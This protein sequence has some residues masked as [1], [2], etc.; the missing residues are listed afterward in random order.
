[1][2]VAR[3]ARHLFV[4][5]LLVV[6]LVSVSA[7]PAQAATG[8]VGGTVV[9]SQGAALGNVS[10]SPFRW[11]EQSGEW[12]V[13]SD[14]SFTADDGSYVISG[15]EPG[16]YILYYEDSINER[17]SVWSNGTSEM[18]ADAD[19]P[20]AFAV[21]DGSEAQ[22]DPVTME[23]GPNAQLEG[24][25]EKPDGSILDGVLVEAFKAGS[26]S[27]A[28]PVASD[29][30]YGGKYHLYVPAGDYRVEYSHLSGDWGNA[31]RTAT[32]VKDDTVVVA[33]VVM[34]PN[35]D[36]KSVSGTVA[37]LPSGTPAQGLSVYLSRVVGTPGSGYFDVF[38]SDMVTTGPG[39]TYHFDKL[40]AGRRYAVSVSQRG[41]EGAW[42]GDTAEA[43]PDS[44]FTAGATASLSTIHVTRL[45]TLTG[46]LTD[47]A[48]PA[49]GVDVQLLRWNAG[50]QTYDFEDS[51]VTDDTG[52]YALYPDHPGTF[53]L[54]ADAD[55][56][57]GPG[58]SSVIGATTLP[59]TAD[60]P[61]TFTLQA[62]ELRTVDDQALANATRIAGTVRD[63]AHPGGIGDVQVTAFRDDGAELDPAGYGETAADGTYR[64]KVYAGP[65]D[66][67]LYFDPPT[68]STG[69]GQWL[70]GLDAQPTPGALVPAGKVT[71]TSEGQS[72][73]GKDI[74]LADAPVLSGVVTSGGQ[75]LAGARV[76]AYQWDAE[77]GEWYSSQTIVTATDG[78]YKI[79]VPG[80]G[81]T[82]TV[83]VAKFGYYRTFLGGG[84]VLPTSPTSSN[85]VVASGP[86]TP[87]PSIAMTAVPQT[88]G[89]LAGTVTGPGGPAEHVY[90]QAC[91]VRGGS[92][93]GGD[94]T[95]H[96]GSWSI[97]NLVTGDYL[98]NYWPADTSLFAGKDTAVVEKDQT[99]TLDTTLGAP[100]TLPSGASITQGGRLAG[101]PGTVPTVYYAE[102]LTL[103][104]PG[105]AGVDNPTYTVHLDDGGADLHGPL[106]FDGATGTYKATVPPFEPR[107]GEATIT[108][109]IPA[110]GGGKVGFDLYIDPSGTVIDQFGQPVSG[111]D[112]E[113]Q[114][115][116]SQG[117]AYT[118]VPDG[119][120]IMSPSNRSNSMQTDANGAFHWDVTAGWYKVVASR[121]GC[122]TGSTPGMQVPP[123]RVDL[124][125]QLQCAAP[126]PTSLPTVT[127]ARSI[128][129]LL[130][131]TAGS[132]AGTWGAPSFQWRRNGV[133]IPGATGT[134][135]RLVPADA[136]QSI[137]VAQ[138][139][140]KD[141]F[142]PV[143]ATSAAVGVARA[144]STGAIRMYAAKIK[145]TQ[146]GIAL[147]TIKAASGL[148][149]TGR[150]TA[151]VDG[152]RYQASGV[153]TA[154]NRG[155]LKI[156]LPKLKK[157][158]HS[159]RATYAG[160]GQVAP[161]ST[162]TTY[163]KVK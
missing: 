39:G 151:L 157:G 159:V 29:I 83:R 47:S 148:L 18:P 54:F 120:T 43:T 90:V 137:T 95:S 63:S 145:R 25:V 23:D 67:T 1:M 71:V 22:R 38:P 123:E 118:K 147:V 122:A 14:P 133:A 10:V 46:R 7:L 79:K 150:V 85:S 96:D 116:D 104:I 44:L 81:D 15:L 158:L 55:R 94:T 153:L 88:H 142:A 32:A 34:S 16:T 102:P 110:S 141:A 11:D 65:G 115:A 93:C 114:R 51:V 45:A 73:T 6:G 17:P 27:N 97:P 52:H 33:T 126:T 149:P 129:S 64:V 69:R 121:T 2:P 82:Y 130:T 154:G 143:T 53:A 74:S 109:N 119:S 28:D 160:S 35:T 124:V 41:F 13:V 78:H 92:S 162:A 99:I 48:G 136:G 21:V 105:A 131:A 77:A 49:R 8:S 66:Y 80:D 156:L 100:S 146:R 155:S 50:D 84:S 163:L 24:R 12:V 103:R 68:R 70:G 108:T 140:Q 111:A 56:S 20:G 101:T 87:V 113:L 132:W 125:L 58:A 9:D 161:A 75:P 128:G 98:V 42:L 61:G 60:G 57:P 89:N 134:T 4:A 135:Y 59:T 152:G 19:S 91:P 139:Q 76:R 40:I 86:V 36:P 37:A 26:T 5:L 138:T 72:I 127:G 62:S 117:G 106:V 31:L 112:A 144:A 3:L 107:H 30:T